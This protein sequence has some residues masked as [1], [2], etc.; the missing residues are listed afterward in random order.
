MGFA[1]PADRSAEA[2][3]ELRSVFRLLS[4]D[5]ALANELVASARNEAGRRR[6]AAESDAKAILAEARE[7]TPAARAA[8]MTRVM[9]LASG[10]RAQQLATAQLEVERI[11]Q[12]AARQTPRLADDIVTR[13]LDIGAVSR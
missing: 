3:R 7:S 4:G 8:E 9:D 10:E 11:E 2:D 12:T 13:V 1:V 5:Q 6:A